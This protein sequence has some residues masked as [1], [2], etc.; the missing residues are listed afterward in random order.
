ME[1][2]IEILTKPDNIPIVFM[3]PLFAFFLW[4]AFSQA[5]R[6]DR[7]IEKGKKDDVYDEMIR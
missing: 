6:H 3:M 7:L 1:H 5:I 2:F 4:L